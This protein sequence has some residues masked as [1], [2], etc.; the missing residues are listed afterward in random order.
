MAVTP[1]QTHLKAAACAQAHDFSIL[2][3]VGKCGQQTEDAVLALQQ[4]LRNGRRDAKISINLKWRTSV[5]QIGINSTAATIADIHA[6][7]R[8][9][10]LTNQR[11]RVIAITQPRPH[12]CLVRQ[13]PTHAVIAADFQCF[14]GSF[15]SA[16]LSKS[17]RSNGKKEPLPGK[18][19]GLLPIAYDWE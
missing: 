15:R 13:R 14:A 1:D 6:I 19:Q 4:H 9:K 16:I 3:R 8:I 17:K 7:G 10:R 2:P 12:Q 11:P 5:E 18:S